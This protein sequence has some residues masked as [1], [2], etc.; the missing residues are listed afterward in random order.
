VEPN[1]EFWLFSRKKL[2]SGDFPTYLPIYETYFL[3]N[4]LPRGNQI[5]TQLRF[6]HNWSTNGH[7]MD[8]ALVGCWFTMAHAMD[9]KVTTLAQLL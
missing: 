4:W 2:K 1:R 7:P 9:Q 6:I 3:Q 8:G 5:L